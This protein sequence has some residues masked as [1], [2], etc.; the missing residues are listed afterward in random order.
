MC[1]YISVVATT[2]GP[3]NLYAAP[4]LNSHGDARAGW[5]ITGGAEVEWVGESHDYLTVRHEDKKIAAT[6][7]QMLIDRYP[8]RSALLAEIIETRGIGAN[9]RQEFYRDGKLHREDGPAVIYADGRQEFYRD[10]KLHR[11]DGPAVIYANGRQEFYRD[12]K[13][14]RED[15]PAVIDANGYQALDRKSV[16]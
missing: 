15:G 10:G 6:I 5:K 9:G 16:V 12:G 8:N 13:L 14:H 2:E 3:L 11:E 4:G 7:R 1:E